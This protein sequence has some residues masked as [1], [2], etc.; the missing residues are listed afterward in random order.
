[1]KKTL[2]IFALIALFSAV[3]LAQPE[4]HLKLKVYTS[5]QNDI[6][7]LAKV[8]VNL[9][10]IESKPGQF[11]IGEFS[12]QEQSIIKEAGFSFDVL[13][14]DMTEFYV[15]RNKGLNIAEL[16]SNIKGQRRAI[17]NSTTPVNFKLGSMGGYHTYSELLNELDEMRTLFPGL[18]SAKLPIDGGLTIENRPVYWVRISNSP[19]INQDKRRVLY[20]ALTHAREPAGMQ[21]MLYQM[22]YLLENY[23]T[24]AEIK[25]LVDNLEIYFIPCVN[26][27]GY[28]HNETTNPNGGGYWRKNRRINSGSTSIGVDLNRNFGYNWGYDDTGSSPNGSTET[29]RGTAAFSEPE[30]QLVK[31][32]VETKNFDLALNNHTYSN[33]LI[34]PW[35]Y[36]NETTP[37]AELLGTYASLMTE[38][39]G[40]AYGTCYQTLNYTANGGSDDWF[41]GE[42]TTKNK[43]LAFTPEA[44]NP[45][46]GFWPAANKIEEICAGH[47]NMNLYIVRFAVMYAKTVEKAPQLVG[48]FQF[49]VPF[50]TTC[51]GID[52]PA[53]FT[54]SLVPI[55]NNIEQV[56]DPVSFNEMTLLEK[57]SG[58]FS[59]S[60]KNGIA[61]GDEIKFV[62]STSNGLFAFTDTV[63][64]VFGFSEPIITD[65]CNS[66]TNWTSSSWGTTTAQYVSP[67]SSITD[68]PTGNYLSNANTH[69]TLNQTI[70][71]SEATLASVE[72]MAR[73]DI[74][75]NWD[76]A[77]LVA[78]TDGGTTWIPLVGNHTSIGGSNQDEDQPL[79][80]GQ[81]NQWVK[82]T[83]SLDQFLGQSVKL[84]FKLVADSY[85]E[86]DGFYF[87]DFI[88]N[89]SYNA[90]VYKMK[91]PEIIQYKKGNSIQVDFSQFVTADPTSNV[92][93][94]WEGNDNINIE[95]SD[96]DLAFQSND[97]EWVGSNEVTF[98][99]TGN[100]G[101]I[102]QTL[103]VE[104]VE[105]ATV[106]IITGQNELYTY[107]NTPIAISLSDISVDDD[108]SSF[109]NDFSLTVF[110][111]SNFTFNELTIL[112]VAN[113]VGLL[114][115]PIRVSD[116]ENESLPYSLK[117]DVRTP[118][119]VEEPVASNPRI[120]YSAIQQI[121]FVELTGGNIFNSLRLI[122]A[123]G[124][125]HLT[126]QLAPNDLSIEISLGNRLPSGVYFIQLLGKEP[127]VKKVMIY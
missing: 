21:Q 85:I 105:T 13:V 90:S 30:T 127:S 70:D 66:L 107:K 92:T 20:T 95:S 116:G 111:F 67:S 112:P 89:R 122:D 52:T 50:E 60:L 94:S 14:P 59:V 44:G 79:Y 86:K 53:N 81:Q 41:Y 42:Q 87:D 118:L 121:V 48:S 106:P 91:L 109:P 73:W 57:R 3:S 83:V 47:T 120:S 31:H 16:N 45:A 61:G 123:Y 65:E 97:N 62:L 36:A 34:Y 108:D 117:I 84:R 101:Y 32:F 58:N 39:N 124:R 115:V 43:V 80:H 110:E 37:D 29:Y 104:C 6:V 63:T 35:G 74:E 78:S 28:V 76:Y 88:V 9:E 119:E 11:I 54:V 126:K 8:G 72:F 4:K 15:S 7:T 46:D 100:L 24:N 96:W 38:T 99:L 26:P 113:F 10:N 12:E 68:S 71:L 1:V 5:A 33:I 51:L 40:Y 64:K 17:K 2:I 125:V 103:T 75:T 19:D 102:S 23:E 56:G 27:D 69:I 82:E 114:S 98:T 93:I 55:S 25:Y 18:I 22:W 77:Q 49:I